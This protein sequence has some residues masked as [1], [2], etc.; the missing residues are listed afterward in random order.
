MDKKTLSE[1]DFYR[2]RSDIASFCSAEESVSFMNEI[3]PLTDSAKIEERKTLGREWSLMLENAHASLFLGWHPVKNT[4]KSVL[5]K[6]SSLNL[7]EIYDIWL[8]SESV[9]KT[10]LAVLSVKESLGL[11]N[12]PLLCSSMPSLC[13][14]A[15][16]I[17]RIITPAGELRDL[18][19]LR[20]I[21]KKIAE[22]R[23]KIKDIMHSIIV[24]PKYSSFFESTVPVLRGERQ[25]L[26]VKSGFRSAVPGIIHD[27][28]QSGKTL[29][30]EPEECVLCSN[31]LVE[32]EAE[33]EIATR[34]ILFELTEKIRPYAD[35]F[36]NA[37]KTMEILDV[38]LAFA[39]WG[40]AHD[41]VWAAGIEEGPLFL[42]KARHPLLG[43]KAVP[44][45]VRFVEG[46]KI[47]IISGPN[48]GGKTVAVKTI[49]LFSMMNQA[50]FPLPC[51]EGTRLPIFSDI[52]SDIGD[53]QNMDESLSTFSGHM[54]NIAHA[55]EKA[56]SSSLVI[57]D[58]F[59]SGTDPEEGSAISMAV[60]DRLIEK[61]SF[62]LITTHHGA[63]KNYG[64]THKECINASVEFSRELSGPTYRLLMGVP[65]ESHALTIAEKSG[66]PQKIIEKAK[67]YIA[68]EKA[69]ISSL[70]KALGE[71]YTELSL[72]EKEFE[73]KEAE[74][75]DKLFKAEKM[76]VELLR[77]E[78]ELEKG[79]HIEAEDF[80]V[81]SRKQLENL[82]RTLREGEI[83]R[84]KTLSVK[85]YIAE[86]TEAVQKRG[87]EA[88]QKEENI[89][90]EEK[91]VFEKEKKRQ[92][93]KK[94]REKGRLS[95]SEAFSLAVP[96]SDSFPPPKKNAFR[97]ASEKEKLSYEIGAEV[98][99]GSGKLPGV[100]VSRSGDDKWFVQVG[101][102]KMSMKESDLELVGKK[103]AEKPSISYEFSS[104]KNEATSPAFELRLL[105]M[106]VE[107]AVRALNHQMD[108]CCIHGFKNFSIIHGKGTG[109]LQQSVQ[110]Y[111]SN[112]ASV[113]SFNFAL[114]E[115]GGFG[116]T[117]VELW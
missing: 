94:N 93:H 43:S 9:R 112:C 108:L 88:L 90:L 86:L 82:V 54:K 56:D 16:D 39:K 40:K 101:A 89:F 116:K 38:T 11:E 67:S 14:P 110:D 61:K 20:E 1:L 42:L 35:D 55:L 72:K 78:M 2:I 104:E 6:G 19:E 99:A 44:I 21:R 46:K 7:T 91:N 92:S 98:L 77:R 109:V 28:S 50:G 26:A 117:Y 103:T 102:I 37:L 25:V 41:C 97:S 75:E 62:V 96:M 79:F 48:T 111:L 66:I 15:E 36:L 32:A 106:R 23:K 33:L 17:S 47:L 34:K 114:P 105:G 30:I 95:S 57:L 8:F 64:Y 59:G 10:V 27:V 53:E 70:I 51:R 3:E 85:K 45:D 31:L 68:G 81:Q 84:E 22:L 29:Y 73:R 60:L 113:K 107:E 63:I 52:F 100:I 5:S 4:V 74:L 18:K 87:E 65:G 69:N 115:D 12:L 80:L 49:A 24:D 83:T 76:R 58:E 71:K 13:V